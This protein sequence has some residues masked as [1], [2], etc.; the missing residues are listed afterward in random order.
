MCNTSTNIGM[1][2]SIHTRVKYFQL[3]YNRSKSLC[4]ARDLIELLT[5][6]EAKGVCVTDEELKC[7]DTDIFNSRFDA[8]VVP[9][10]MDLRAFFEEPL[11]SELSK[12]MFSYAYEMYRMLLCTHPSDKLKSYNKCQEFYKKIT[13]YKSNIKS[14][15]G[16]VIAKSTTCIVINALASALVDC[17]K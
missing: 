5:S 4:T 12:A 17:V 16:P 7:I 6:E 10:L 11:L 3:C 13:E 1:E 15:T 14:Y 2:R 9:P 8:T